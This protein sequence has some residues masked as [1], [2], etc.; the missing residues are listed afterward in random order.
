MSE[1]PTPK[2]IRPFSEKDN[3]VDEQRVS[4][5]QIEGSINSSQ[6]MP[7]SARPGGKSNKKKFFQNFSVKQ[8]GSKIGGFTK[9]TGNIMGGIVNMSG[10]VVGNIGKITGVSKI[11]GAF[12]Y[13][14][15]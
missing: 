8:I 2:E 9:L 11:A 4:S 14:L 3:E 13:N 15:A 1:Q 12:K 7:D 5:A 6:D 10:N